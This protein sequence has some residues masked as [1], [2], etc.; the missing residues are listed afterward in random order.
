M[1]T[2]S[3]I[4]ARLAYG[5]IVLPILIFFIGWCNPLVAVLGSI[6]ILVSFYFTCKNAPELWSPTSR[7]QW[8]FLISLVLVALVWVCWS[9]I[10]ALVFQ[11]PDHSCRNPIFELL[12]TKP[13]PVLAEFRKGF[14]ST[15]EN[16]IV[17]TYYIGFWLPPA[18]VGKVF[19]S[20]QIGYYAQIIWATFGVFLVFYYILASVKKKNYLP[21][22]LFLIFSG[23]DFLGA[24]LLKKFYLYPLVR[25]IEW[26]LAGFNYE[27]FTTQLFWVFNQAL[28]AWLVTVMLLHEK[29][30]KSILFLYSCLLI[31]ATLPSMGLFPIVAYLMLKN[32]NTPSKEW[33]DFNY[34]KDCI[35]SAFTFQNTL[36]MFLITV[37]SY[38]YLT[39][40][41]SGGNMGIVPHLWF[42]ILVY[43]IVYFPI[44]VGIYLAVV[45]R[46]NKNNPLLYLITAW[47]L[48]IPHIQVGFTIDFGMRACIPSLVILFLFVAKTL[49]EGKIQKDKFAYTILILALII[50]SISPLHEFSRTVIRTS[51]GITKAKSELSVPNFFA[52][53]QDNKFLMYFGKKPKGVVG[54]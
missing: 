24:T 41:I 51:R 13:W 10:G 32:G 48:I 39:Q 34:I 37:I 17:M 7:K 18:L 52:Y 33:F 49:D 46:Y 14:F 19:N 1:T 43:M 25:N 2:T 36:G 35:K 44:E 42:N 11:N 50:G 3:K 40:N 26:W 28:P 12:V 27:S 6:I 53:I 30:N 9:G 5:Y 20:V 29:N 38:F 22:F 15:V 21:I 4:F 8:F 16:P 45:W 23:M 47:L 31:H 54:E